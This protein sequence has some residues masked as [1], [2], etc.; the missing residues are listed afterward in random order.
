VEKAFRSGETFAA[1]TTDSKHPDPIA[2]NLLVRSFDATAP[3]PLLGHGR[4][5]R[6]SQRAFRDNQGGADPVAPY[7]TLSGATDSIGEYIDNFYNPQRRRS[8][9]G[10]ISP[11][12]VELQDQAAAFAA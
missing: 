4:D 12:E 5:V 10:Y 11:I 3:E 2:R 8:H 7:D 9:L 1:A 6:L